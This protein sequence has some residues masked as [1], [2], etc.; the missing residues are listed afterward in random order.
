MKLS[1]R[2]K[3]TL[4]QYLA[5]SGIPCKETNDYFLISIKE[6]D[7]IVKVVSDLQSIIEDIEIT[8][9]TMNDVFITITGKEIR[10]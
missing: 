7:K 6:T 5:A 8:K 10:E 9:G 4:L 3:S 2:N 1:T